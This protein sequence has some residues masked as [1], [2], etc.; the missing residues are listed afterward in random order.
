MGMITHARPLTFGTYRTAFS[1]DKAWLIRHHTPRP[2]QV[3]GNW[4]T[5]WLGGGGSAS[6]RGQ[7][8][9]RL[10]LIFG[11]RSSRAAANHALACEHTIWV[12]LLNS[13]G[14]NPNHVDSPSLLSLEISEAFAS[15]EVV[16]S[17]TGVGSPV[18]YT[19][20]FEDTTAWCSSTKAAF[21]Y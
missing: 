15:E 12:M 20:Y 18:E 6:I 21:P 10:F 17:D 7:R 11:I 8:I 16:T 14:S 4:L 19:E 9:N 2:I 1:P 13:A 5:K 3:P